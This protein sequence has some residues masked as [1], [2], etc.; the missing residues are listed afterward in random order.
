MATQAQ[1]PA[2]RRN[3]QK[4]TGPKTAEGK[5]TA[6]KNATQHGLF[7]RYDV[8]ISEDQA[9]Y[10][11]LR[12]SLLDELAPEGRSTTRGRSCRNRSLRVSPCPPKAGRS[13]RI[14]VTTIRSWAIWR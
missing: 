10:D 4:S 8:V 12:E 14:S 9:N 3:A 6:A 5:A 7:A 13:N 2:N 1:I 11:A